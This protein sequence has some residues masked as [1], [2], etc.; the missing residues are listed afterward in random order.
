MDERVE[1]FAAD[2]EGILLR[3]YTERENYYF[4]GDEDNPMSPLMAALGVYYQNDAP[5]TLM[6][7]GFDTP[8]GELSWQ[9]EFATPYGD[10]DYVE[11]GERLFLTD[12]EDQR[13]FDELAYEILAKGNIPDGWELIPR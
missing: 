5:E 6:G 13:I 2:E 12:E 1:I 3:S 8:R 7:L 9:T 4:E 10:E 11:L